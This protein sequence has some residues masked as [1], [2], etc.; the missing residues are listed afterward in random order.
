MPPRKTGKADV[1]RL[2]R[3]GLA[4]AAARRMRGE[5]DAAALR[6]RAAEHQRGAGRRVDLLVVMHLENLDVEAVVERL[7]HALGQRRQQIDAEAHVAGLDDRPRSWR[8]P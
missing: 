8:T 7:R 6:R 3:A 4:V 1:A 5:I 2:A